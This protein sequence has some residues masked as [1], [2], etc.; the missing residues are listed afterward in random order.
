MQIEQKMYKMQIDD[1]RKYIEKIATIKH[2]IKNQILCM[3]ELLADVAPVFVATVILLY[4][5]SRIA[6]KRAVRSMINQNIIEKL[7]TVE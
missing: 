3:S 5:G 2:N 4:F 6:V 7:N 1:A